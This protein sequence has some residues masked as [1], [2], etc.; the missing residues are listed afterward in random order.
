MEI[1]FTVPGVPVPYQRVVPKQGQAPYNPPKYR[2]Y[3]KLVRL[4]AMRAMEG[5]PYTEKPIHIKITVYHTK[6]AAS[7]QSGDIDNHLKAIFDSLNKVV[8]KDDGQIVSVRV[9]KIKKPQDPHIE[10]WVS[11][12]FSE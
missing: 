9:E 3:R 11:D 7:K 4:F 12:E 1:K 8:F 2:E 10:V 6:K 5:Q